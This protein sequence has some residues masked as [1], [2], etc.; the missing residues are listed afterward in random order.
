[1]NNCKF[2]AL[3]RGK[4]QVVQLEKF[5]IKLHKKNKNILSVKKKTILKKKNYQS[6]I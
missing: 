1:M 4:L 5:K 2:Q 3:F 6:K